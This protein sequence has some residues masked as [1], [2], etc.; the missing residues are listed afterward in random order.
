M[1][2][3]IYKIFKDVYLEE[4]KKQGKEVKD[5]FILYVVASALVDGI[6]DILRNCTDGARIK[7]L[8]ESFITIILHNMS[9][10][11]EYNYLTLDV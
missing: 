6:G 5:E 3:L 4:L 2:S 9:D 11:I 1:K 8:A 7:L 10:R